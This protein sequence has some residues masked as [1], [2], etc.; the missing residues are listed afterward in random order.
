MNHIPG[1]PDASK[2]ACPVREGVVGNVKRGQTLVQV[3][4]R[5]CSEASKEAPVSFFTKVPATTGQNTAHNAGEGSKVTRQRAGYLLHGRGH[6]FE[7][8]IAH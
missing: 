7:F 8:C 4:P 5:F 2:G 6:R 3:E 1:E